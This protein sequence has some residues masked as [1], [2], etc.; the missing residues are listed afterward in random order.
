MLPAVWNHPSAGA[1][2]L[3]ASIVRDTMLAVSFAIMS[4]SFVGMTAAIGLVVLSE[5]C[6]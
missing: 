2:W 3:W 4:S 5:R 6:N 1:W